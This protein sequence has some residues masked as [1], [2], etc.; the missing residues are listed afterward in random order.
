MAA[1]LKSLLPRSLFARALAILLVPIVVLQLVV[2]LVFFQRHYLRVTEQMTRGVAFELA[3]AAEQVEAAGHPS[4]PRAA[5]PSSALPLD[6]HLRWS[7]TAAVEPGVER[8]A[9]DATGAKLAAT[10]AAEIDR[11]LQVDLR[12]DEN[13]ARIRI[14]TDAGVLEAVVPRDRLSVSNPHQ[15]L[16]LM[17]LAACLLSAIAVIF[18]RNQVRP[19]R[20]LAEA[21]EAFGKGRA[22]PFRLAGAEEVRRAGAAFLAMR[23]RIERQIEQRTQMLSG[24]SHD[25]RTPLTRMK[26]TL[27][28]LEETD[29]TRDLARDAAEMEAM[30]EAFLAFARGDGREEAVPT[31]PF[32]LAAGVAE[33]ARR[34][35]ATI[36]L[37]ETNETP[38][39][40]LV[41]LRPGAVARA[42]TNL[43]GNA[44]RHGARVALNVRLS[45]QPRLRGRGRRPRHPRGRP[46]PA[47]A[48]SPGSTQR[49]TSTP[50]AMSGSASPSPSTSPA[51][52]AAA[53]SS[54]TARPS[55]G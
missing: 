9:L 18:L 29:E 10:L 19:I 12:S 54:A 24:V 40:P 22:L 8:E 39:E 6:L 5:W 1:R 3:Y 45:A 27:A 37:A 20:V 42:L 30:L 23:A 52:T 17:I 48:P 43:V 47:L 4:A 7:T 2:G 38:R 53:S 11:P 36:S 13:F 51:A 33:N 16:V 31:D 28:L 34:A 32:A 21:A 46:R 35:G 41:R 25:L 26:L 50:A 14:A 55:A 49:A 44:A 15:L